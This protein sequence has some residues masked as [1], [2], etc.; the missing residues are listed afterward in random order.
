M[1]A[2]TE[3]GLFATEKGDIYMIVCKNICKQYGRQVVLAD[4]SC[5]FGDTGFYLLYGESGSGKT[6][7]INILSGMLPFDG[8]TVS[9]NAVEHDSQVCLPDAGL[10]FDYITQDTFFADFLTVSDN[11]R[12]ISED[13]DKIAEALQ[14]FGLMQTA[15][16]FPSTLSGG[17]RQRLALARAYLARKKI[18]FLD[19]PTASL[20]EENKKAVFALLQALKED[21]LII[22][23]SHDAVA[24]DYADETVLFQKCTATTDTPAAGPAAAVQRKRRDTARG[25]KPTHI[26]RYLRKWF[27]SGK[28]VRRPEVKFCIFLT[29]AIA[30]VMLGDIPSHKQE[31][32]FTE[33]YRVNALNLQTI[34]KDATDYETLAAMPG[35]KKVVLSYAGSTP[36]ER[37]INDTDPESDFVRPEYVTSLCTLP[38]EKQYFPLTECIVHGG[39][40]TSEYQVILSYE[41][42]EN[43]SPGRHE[44]LVGSTITWNVYSLGSTQF[45]IVGVM[46]KLNRFEQ[47]Y[48]LSLDMDYDSMYFNSRLT[49]RFI[50]DSSYYMGE[51]RTYYI[52]FDSYRELSAF[53]DKYAGAFEERHEHLGI[54]VR[55]ERGRESETIQLL[56][57]VLVPLSVFIAILTVLFYT[58]LLKTE[59]AYN[60]RFIAVFE[61]SGY[62]KK[63]VIACFI[64]IHML[65][66]MIMCVISFGAA[67]LAAEVVNAINRRTVFVGFQ[68]FT[69][70]PPLMVAFGMLVVLL[71]L[72]S[73]YIS[74]YRLKVSSWY[75]NLIRQ[76]DLL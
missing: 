74:L 8:G 71:S 63:R 26:L 72:L 10:D 54:G 35:V 24:R 4:F 56:G 15:D 66:L 12:L 51:Q 2:K 57:I 58:N 7:L 25:Q 37:G 33:S 47:K 44:S 3:P 36:Y 17:E 39:Y 50:N 49:D 69:L 40:F 64:A 61:Y 65:R 52:Y 62:S 9:V 29:L 5:R 75:E 55:V 73:A 31:V 46:R 68:L 41:E 59:I 60:N 23:S 67:F 18:L 32:N 16:Q 11:L 53:Y 43:L 27:S 13:G 22:C 48:F 6:T 42:A 34:S 76:R 38:F 28:R 19:E 30:L 14:R 20:D 45:E 1:E 70:N 21:T